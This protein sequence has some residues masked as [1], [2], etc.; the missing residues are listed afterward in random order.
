MS[1]SLDSS[2]PG[3][4]G[5]GMWDPMPLPAIPPLTPRSEESQTTSL[6]D[7]ERVPERSA[8][9]PK[10]QRQKAA[11]ATSVKTTTEVN[12]ARKTRVGKGR[13]KKAAKKAVQKKA[14]KKAVQ[15]K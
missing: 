13:G 3:L 10:K 12:A 5:P 14:A 6:R 8:R 1:T 11:G 4:G 9:E 2:G 7:A 15:K